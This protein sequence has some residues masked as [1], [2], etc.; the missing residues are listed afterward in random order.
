MKLPNKIGGREIDLL[1]GI[2]NQLLLPTKKYQLSESLGLYESRLTDKNGSV[3]VYAGSHKKLDTAD[4][5]DS[6][7]SYLNKLRR[8]IPESETFMTNIEDQSYNQGGESELREEIY[9]ISKKETQMCHTLDD[10]AIINK[11]KE[12]DP[13]FQ[14]EHLITYRCNSCADCVTCKSSNNMTA[15]S[16]QEQFEQKIIESSVNIDT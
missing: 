12:Y 5:E 15:I 6:L 2:K 10:F 14:E 8:E 4:T 9:G 7:V 16:K 11:F 3:L 1:I 13:N